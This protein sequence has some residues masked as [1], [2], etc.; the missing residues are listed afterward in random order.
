MIK[1]SEVMLIDSDGQKQGI[2]NIIDALEGRCLEKR[3]KSNGY[4]SVHSKSRK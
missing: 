3:L 1:A 4:H 2:V